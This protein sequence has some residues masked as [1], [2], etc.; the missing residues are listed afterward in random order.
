[1]LANAIAQLRPGDRVVVEGHRVGEG[2]RHGE[3]IEVLGEPG[4][5]RCRV[6]WGDGNE[7][8][9]YPGADIR[10]ESTA[11]EGEEKPA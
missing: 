6:R 2:A 7:T 10:V 3:I 1:M 8:L 4:R 5:E 11:S 9:V